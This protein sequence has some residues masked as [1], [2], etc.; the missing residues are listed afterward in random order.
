V[1]ATIVLLAF[2]LAGCLGSHGNGDGKEA[3]GTVD[4]AQAPASFDRL[5]GELAANSTQW[6][7]FLVVED[8]VAVGNAS[9]Q[10][11]TGRG[12]GCQG[13]ADNVSTGRTGWV[14]C[15]VR[16]TARPEAMVQTVRDLGIGYDAQRLSARQAAEAV[17][18]RAFVQLE[19]GTTPFDS[20]WRPVDLAP[21]IS[22]AT[23]TLDVR[24]PCDPV[25]PPVAL[26]NPGLGPQAPEVD[27][28]LTIEVDATHGRPFVRVDLG[29]SAPGD[30]ESTPYGAHGTLEHGFEARWD[31]VGPWRNFTLELN[32]DLEAAESP[33]GPMEGP[34]QA[35]V[36]RETQ[37]WTVDV[38]IVGADGK[39]ETKRQTLAVDV[40]L[41]AT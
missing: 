41:D 20:G 17:E 24:D 27:A 19:D 10:F 14:A 15:A 9:L 35:T 28:V 11:T 18:W 39:L 32:V 21:G 37:Q 7:E 40:Y 5:S 25:E 34:C 38:G 31:T 29:A 22:A 6:Q 36:G 16:L 30:G 33:S 8:E 2:L 3:G 1:R 23:V 4:P 26:P 13:D 12:M